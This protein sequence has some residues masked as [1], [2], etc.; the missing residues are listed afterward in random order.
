MVNKIVTREKTSYEWFDIIYEDDEML[1]VNK[2]SGIATHPAGRDSDH[3][4]IL[5]FEKYL[6]Y[7]PWTLMRLD[8]E[9]SGI[10]VF[11]KVKEC[12]SIINKHIRE[13]NIK[14]K[15][16]CVVFGNPKSQTI[17]GAIGEVTCDC[18]KGW[19]KSVDGEGAKH[20]VTIIENIKSNGDYSL[21]D[22]KTL[23]GRQHQIRVHLSHIGHPLVGDKLY[24][25]DWIFDTY[26]N[27]NGRVLTQDMLDIIKCDRLLLHA[28]SLEFEYKGESK[29]FEAPIPKVFNKFI[30]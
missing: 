10:M 12:A 27:E 16:E 1:V 24:K 17:D 29:Y 14:K 26:S 28:K 8:R 9:T 30:N 11:G 23:T 13:R 4:L 25:E 20:A 15:Y 6:G 19:K 22:V 5:E 21:I 2:K 7:R 18:L 3:N